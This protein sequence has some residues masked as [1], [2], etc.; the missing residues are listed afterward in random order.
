MRRPEGQ[1]RLARFHQTKAEPEVT[2]GLAADH[3]AVVEGRTLFPSR[4]MPTA[5]S[6]RFL[7]SGQNNAKIGKVV[8]KGPWAGMPIFTLTLEERKTCPRS[9]EQW[10]DCYGNAMQWPQRWDHTD[11]AF[12]PTL[13]AELITLGRQNPKGFVVRLHVLGDFFSVRYVYFWAEMLAVIPSLRVYGYT[14]RTV[15]DED[16][17]SARIAVALDI[18]TDAM[19]SRFAI[20]TSTSDPRNADSIAMVVE[21]AEEAKAAGALLCPAQTSATETCG[22]CA[23]CWSPNL[24]D[25]A[26]AF[27]RHGMKRRPAKPA[28]APPVKARAEGQISRDPA[29]IAQRQ[30]AQDEALLKT[31]QRLGAGRAAIQITLAAL[32]LESGIPQGSVLFV[33]RRLAE[34]GRLVITKVPQAR[35]PDLNSYR[36]PGA[37][38]PPEGKPKDPDQRNGADRLLEAMKANA[39]PDGLVN[40]SRNAL[41]EA[42]GV[43]LGSW[44]HHIG[45]LVRRKAI[46]VEHRGA[47]NA[48]RYR[49]AGCTAP[50]ARQKAPEC[51]GNVASEKPAPPPVAEGVIIRRPPR[52]LPTVSVDPDEP[53]TCAAPNSLLS[54]G[55]GK[56]K[57]PLNDPP[58]GR[59]DLT[60]FCCE[61]AEAGESYCPGHL[62]IA[63]ASSKPKAALSEAQEAA[64][65]AAQSRAAHRASL[66]RAEAA[67]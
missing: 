12:L 23:L 52:P 65:K 57:W 2:V 56:C 62:K 30:A 31:L 26:I 48:R 41:A 36:L 27:L 43:R 42:S 55:L 50:P 64:I 11:P 21:S 5:G 20:R 3:P 6:M 34:A 45:T 53:L 59:A 40:A 33:A 44:E 15:F 60:T 19:W 7:V 17:A 10:R 13:Q 18:L 28:A 37:P 46:T 25:K 4:V 24:R 51:A 66:R 49:I 32:H 61:K 38:P 29:V 35:G 58:R 54:L 47:G 1:A 22:T 16:Q 39:G 8:E 63:G 14:A 9:C 67:L